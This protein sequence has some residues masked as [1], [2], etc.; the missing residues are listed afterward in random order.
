MKTERIYSSWV[1]GFSVW[2]GVWFLLGFFWI[3]SFVVCFFLISLKS[4]PPWYYWKKKVS[5]CKLNTN[6]D[7]T[8]NNLPV[9]YCSG[10]SFRGDLSRYLST[11]QKLP[12]YILESGSK[13]KRNQNTVYIYLFIYYLFFST[14]VG[15]NT[16][17]MNRVMGRE[18]SGLW[19]SGT[20]E[21]WHTV[22]LVFHTYMA[23]K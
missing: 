4:K 20:T 16:E 6:T 8:A 1:G 14:I 19:F 23:I 21:G 13:K 3:D 15:Q 7:G 9:N 5:F 2:F 22:E 18:L 17:N 11:G 12:W 10:C